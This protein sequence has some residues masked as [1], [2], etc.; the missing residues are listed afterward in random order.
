MSD[1]APEAAREL[2]VRSQDP[3]CAGASLSHLDDELTP[4]RHFFIRNHFAIPRLDPSSWALSVW[5]EVERPFMLRYEDLKGLPSKELVCLLECAG[6]SRSTMQ[7]PAEGVPWDHGAVGTARWKG[8]PL[9]VVLEQ[10][11]LRPKSTN[12]LFEGADF[13]K[14]RTAPG[15]LAPTE[16]S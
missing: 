3:L 9:A 14:E 1:V 6:N 11:S 12:V 16:G 2:N 13:G 5:G 15:I 7:P 4:T 8:V 10:A